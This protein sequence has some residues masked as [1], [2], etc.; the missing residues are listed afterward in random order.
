MSQGVA[1]DDLVRG[2]GV[3][4][5]NIFDEKTP[6]L[7]PLYKQ[8]PNATVDEFGT[9]TQ[10]PYWNTAKRRVLTENDM[11]CEE[12]NRITNHTERTCDICHTKFTFGGTKGVVR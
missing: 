2:K 7:S 10:L 8:I 9:I 12:C 6:E 1:F 5:Q 3:H 4:L 11:W